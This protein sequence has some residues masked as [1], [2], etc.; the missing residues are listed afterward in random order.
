MRSSEPARV[1]NINIAMSA[2]RAPWNSTWRQM[3]AYGAV[4][5]PYDQRPAV[6]RNALKRERS[7]ASFR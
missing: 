7:D 2:R 6:A 5:R 1:E 3:P 4:G